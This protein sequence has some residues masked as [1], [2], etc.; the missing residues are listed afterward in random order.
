MDNF[1]I[2]TLWP[3]LLLLGFLG[4]LAWNCRSLL[5]RGGMD[6]SAK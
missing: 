4:M 3:Y 2:S 6:E 1:S 5:K